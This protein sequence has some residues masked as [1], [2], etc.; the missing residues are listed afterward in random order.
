MSF[1]LAQLSLENQLDEI[2]SIIL[3]LNLNSQV[4]LLDYPTFEIE[5]SNINHPNSNQELTA[6]S[7]IKSRFSQIGSFQ[8]EE[9]TILSQNLGQSMFNLN[10]YLGIMNAIQIKGKASV[11]KKLILFWVKNFGYRYTINFI[12]LIRIIRKEN[13]KIKF[14]DNIDKF[15]TLYCL[16]KFITS[17]ILSMNDCEVKLHSFIILLFSH[18]NILKGLVPYNNKKYDLTYIHEQTTQII[19]LMNDGQEIRI[20]PNGEIK[21]IESDLVSNEL[22]IYHRL[23]IMLKQGLICIQEHD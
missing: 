18:N 8:T 4:I 11:V 15:E 13:L 1:K 14:F 3:L 7:T 22:E 9:N 20:S 19:K 23:S 16:M 12:R 17:P 5:R 2:N 10:L 6:S 21:T